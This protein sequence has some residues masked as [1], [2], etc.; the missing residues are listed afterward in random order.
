M[1]GDVNEQDSM[2]ASPGFWV[3][4]GISLALWTAFAWAVLA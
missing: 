2:F 4:A 1:G 3:G